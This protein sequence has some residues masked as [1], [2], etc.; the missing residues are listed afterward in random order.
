MKIEYNVDQDIFYED[1]RWAVFADLR[2][3]AMSVTG[4][5]TQQGFETFTFGSV[6]RG[7]VKP[8]SDIDIILTTR[9]PT[10]RVEVIL[11]EA[12]LNILHKKIVQATPNDIIK[13]QFELEDEIS[14]TVL[15]TDFTHLAFEFYRYG[16][17]VTHA[18][19]LENVR[20]P[21]IDK[22]LVLIQPTP[23]GHHE[24]SVI[25]HPSQA[26]NIVGVS[27]QIVEQRIRVLTRRDKVG[28][29]GIFLN[30]EIGLDESFEEK[31]QELASENQL[32]RRRLKFGV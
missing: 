19:M 10:F 17:A 14:L 29:T 11:N 24:S 6:A 20:V 9:L 7:D 12:H 23:T 30:E 16:G 28:R 1:E 27:S 5:L 3:K 22:R 8:S 31:L 21:G 2:T 13:A 25:D 4:L 26:A 18:Q 32:I 15:L